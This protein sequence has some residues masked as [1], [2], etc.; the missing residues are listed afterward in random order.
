[1]AGLTLVNNIIRV[2]LAN[3]TSLQAVNRSVE[4]TAWL[5][6]MSSQVKKTRSNQL[7]RELQKLYQRIGLATLLM[8]KCSKFNKCDK[9]D[10]SC[11]KCVSV[12]ELVEGVCNSIVAKLRRSPWF[13]WDCVIKYFSALVFLF[14]VTKH[15][16]L[17]FG[18]VLSK[19][20]PNKNSYNLL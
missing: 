12:D 18:S 9:C 20:C 8:K 7:L 10:K 2:E 5:R 16:H 17:R 3:L 19:A 13:K 6:T 15:P 1:M 11:K 14:V 4:E